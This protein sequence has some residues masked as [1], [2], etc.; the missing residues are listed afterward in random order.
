MVRAR[1]AQQGANVAVFERP[2]GHQSKLDSIR[3]RV[4]RI[5]RL[6]DAATPRSLTCPGEIP[7]GEEDDAG[8][9]SLT[10]SR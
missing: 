6:L 1:M 10:I 7:T 4:V 5:V 2:L 8:K 3:D 9:S